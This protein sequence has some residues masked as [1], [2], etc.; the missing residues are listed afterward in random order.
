MA[1]RCF[2][3]HVD[4]FGEEHFG[5]DVGL[6]GERVWR[7]VV[8][9]HGDSGVVATYFDLVEMMTNEVPHSNLQSLR[10]WQLFTTICKDHPPPDIDADQP[11]ARTH[12]TITHHHLP[13]SL[14][15]PAISSP[16]LVYLTSLTL[17][18][19]ITDSS[20][21]L[22]ILSILSNLAVLHIVGSPSS[23]RETS[24]IDDD[25]TRLWNKQARYSNG[26]PRLKMLFLR[27]QLGVSERVFGELEH[28]PA[29]E[30]VVTSRCGIKT[31]EGKKVAKEKGW[32]MTSKAF[33]AHTD[34][35]LEA[36]P[37]GRSYL[38]IVTTFLTSLVSSPAAPSSSPSRP[39]PL[40]PLSPSPITIPLSLIQLGRQP[41]SQS[42]N[43]LLDTQEIACWVKDTDESRKLAEEKRKRGVDKEER[44]MEGGKRVRRIKEA[45]RRDLLGL[46]EGM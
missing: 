9:Q 27:F 14:V 6:M 1:L 16:S 42:T 8:K 33:Y 29:L 38:D 12:K 30:M 10:L 22:S 43:V 7:E 24:M 21:S 25:T 5:G 17:I 18:D 2:L 15:I 46:L 28:F 26:F 40:P 19:K 44:K 34:T 41:P 31:K 32:K 35:I 36:H 37:L 13:L 11:P 3:N 23:T 20:T 45:K 39:T 4:G